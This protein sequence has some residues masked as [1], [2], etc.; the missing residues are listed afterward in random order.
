M[1]GW[2]FVIGAA[3][4]IVLSGSAVAQ[5]DESVQKLEAEMKAMQEQMRTLQR[6]VEDAKAQAEAAEWAASQ[7]VAASKK[8]EGDDLDLKVKWKGAPELSSK[9]GKFKMKVRGRLQADYDSINQDTG[10]TGQPD[11]SAAELRRARLG[12]EGI[13]W[14]DIKYKFE[15][16]FA[17]DETTIKDAYIEYVNLC[18]DLGIRVG[19]FKTFNSLEHM[20]SSRFITFME[21]AAFLDA[22]DLD[23][24]IGAGAIYAKHHYTLAAGVFGPKAGEEETWYDDVK[25]GAARVTAAPINTD[26]HDGKHT[27]VH[28]GASWRQRH[29]SEDLRGN[30][31]P[32][33]DQ[34]FRYRARGADL[35]LADRFVATPQI[36]DQD[37][38]WGLEAALV[39]GPWSVQGEYGQLSTDLAPGFVGANPTYNGWYVEGSWYLTGETRN[40]KHGE[41]G[42]PK[43]KRPVAGGGPGA[44]QLAAKYD[45]LNLSDKATVIA[46]CTTCGDQ[47]TWLLGLNWWLNDYTRVTFNYNESSINGGFLNGANVN[48]GAK[49]KGFGAR[50]QVD[51]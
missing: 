30:P 33:N 34:F 44:W 6:R 11:V 14:Y 48:D 43:V 17:N 28:L 23:R 1:A 12:V 13:L 25:S 37:T 45:V 19:H 36:F 20:T 15:V 27:V 39:W 40:Y 29:G 51:W 21:R 3:G 41:F 42:R 24:M 7:S 5:A 4:A 22:F 32:A 35:H 2:R 31:I 47:E 18:K 8:D 26:D 46:T 50:A 16:D 38:F 9:D 49:I 10:V